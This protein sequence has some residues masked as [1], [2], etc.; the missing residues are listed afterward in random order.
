MLPGILDS[1][2]NVDSQEALVLSEANHIELNTLTN[3]LEVIAVSDPANVLFFDVDSRLSG[4]SSFEL[5]ATLT[6]DTSSHI[7]ANHGSESMDIE[8]S[9]TGINAPRVRLGLFSGMPNTPITP[10]E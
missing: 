4:S 6:A 9:S 1:D 10:G 5:R 2:S 8:F 3:E 7:D